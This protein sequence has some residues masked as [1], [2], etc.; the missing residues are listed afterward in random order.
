MRDENTGRKGKRKH[1][2]EHWE[3][4]TLLLMIYDFLA[5]MV[6]YFTALWIRFACPD[7]WV[8]CRA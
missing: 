5:V 7:N 2:I 3:V 4:V 6:A 8:M 1:F